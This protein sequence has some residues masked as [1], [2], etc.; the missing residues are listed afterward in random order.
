[1]TT[2]TNALSG[3]PLG[4]AI[5]FAALHNKSGLKKREILAGQIYFT[6]LNAFL[7]LTVGVSV[8]IPEAS[9]LLILIFIL[10]YFLMKKIGFSQVI[11]LLEVKVMFKSLS[12]SLSV[13]TLMIFCYFMIV[14]INTAR[15]DI[16]SFISMICLGLV[17]GFSSGAPSLGGL[18]EILMGVASQ[19]V[20]GEA[21]FGVELALIMRFVSLVSSIPF[22]CFSLIRKIEL[23]SV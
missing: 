11:P 23:N 5:K 6:F 19:L 20:I 3:M 12:L 9:I 8:V 16:Y 13:T 1:M 4:T 7:L 18:Q 14:D 17:L 21:L 10:L 15:V 22:L 2:F